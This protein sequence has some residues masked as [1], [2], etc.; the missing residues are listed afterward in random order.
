VDT[1]IEAAPQDNAVFAS[2]AQLA[3]SLLPDVTGICLLDGRLAVRGQSG[4]VDGEAASGVLRGL[5]WSGTMQ[6]TATA[7]A[8]PDGDWLSAIPLE[9]SDGTLLGVFCVR[10]APSD[11]IGS[12][13]RLKPLLECVRRELAGAQPVNQRIHTLTERSSELEWLFQLTSSLKGASDDRRILEELLGAAMQRLDSAF[14]ILLVPERRIR[15]ERDLSASAALRETC[16]HTQQHL[17]TWAQ[18]QN[19]PLIINGSSAGHARHGRPLQDPVSAGG[20]RYRAGHRCARV[21][22]STRRRPTTPLATCSWPGTW[23]ARPRPSSRRSS[24]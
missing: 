22:Q 13:R 5:G 24:I 6:R 23:A 20:A 17:I 9:Q 18:R 12:A 11:A 4:Q 2:F 3:N 15:V 21:L 19:R 16:S 10:R 7:L 8:Q 14:G 1:A